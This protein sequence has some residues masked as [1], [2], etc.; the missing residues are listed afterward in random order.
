[1]SVAWNSQ[2]SENQ[3]LQ[4]KVGYDDAM[5]RKLSAVC[6]ILDLA[7]RRPELKDELLKPFLEESVFKFVAGGAETYNQSDNDLNETKLSHNLAAFRPPPGLEDVVPMSSMVNQPTHLMQRNEVAAKTLPGDA[8]SGLHQQKKR[9]EEARSRTL[10]LAYLPRDAAEDDVAAAVDSAMGKPGCVHRARIVRDRAGISECYGFFEFVD[11]ITA[12]HVN[13]ACRKGH[14][15]IDDE[16]G[17]TWHVRASRARRAI[18]GS[19]TAGRKVRG[20][21]GRRLGS[22][23]NSE[24]SEN[25]GVCTG[26]P[27]RSAS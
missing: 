26:A 14:V 8:P 18:V 25:Y 7:C 13:E 2:D 20:R 9:Q 5:G 23:S 24:S 11:E 17:H 12:T 27:A 6:A 4:G 15:V 19:V 16:V 22:E 21:R 1:M 3:L 10:V